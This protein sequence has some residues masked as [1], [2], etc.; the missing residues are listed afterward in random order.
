MVIE[1]SDSSIWSEIYS[2]D[3]KIGEARSVSSI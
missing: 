2:R 1:L 3:F